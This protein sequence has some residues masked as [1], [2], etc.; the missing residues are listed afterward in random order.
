MPVLFLLLVIIN[1]DIMH[2]HIKYFD[3]Q[4]IVELCDYENKDYSCCNQAW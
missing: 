1:W 2:F 3:S 4:L